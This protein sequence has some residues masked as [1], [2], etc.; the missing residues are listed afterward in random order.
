MPTAAEIAKPT[1][2]QPS[3]TADVV[4]FTRLTHQDIEDWE[5][6]HDE[7]PDQRGPDPTKPGMHVMVIGRQNPPY[8]HEEGYYCI[9]GGFNDYAED[10]KHAAL[11]ELEEET[12][13]PRKRLPKL[14]L[15]G[16]YGAPDRDP[17]RHVVTVA[18][19]CVLPAAKARVAY[20][21][22][23]AKFV[24]WLRLS[25]VVKGSYKFG[26]DHLQIVLDA[27]KVGP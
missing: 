27:M 6:W 20:G 26:F 19:T 17:R 10:P 4:V 9:P 8:P 25:D 24:T 7:Y 21:G 22:D 18:W 12:H 5:G 23:D 15:V 13:L 16:V 3:L 1:F 14:R 11:R 2:R